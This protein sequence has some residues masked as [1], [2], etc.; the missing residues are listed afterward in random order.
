MT[1]KQATKSVSRDSAALLGVKALGLAYNH[2]N[3]VKFNGPQYIRWTNMV[4]GEIKRVIQDAPLA[5]NASLNSLSVEL[6]E[7]IEM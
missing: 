7:P 5:I 3:L 2:Q 4:R 1:P 6:N